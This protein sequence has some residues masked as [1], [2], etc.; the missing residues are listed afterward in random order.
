MTQ[1]IIR[2]GKIGKVGDKL[3]F[4]AKLNE[5]NVYT[6]SNRKGGLAFYYITEWTEE[7]TG[8][9]LKVIFEDYTSVG[10]A[11]KGYRPG[12]IGFL[13]ATVVEHKKREHGEEY[14]TVLNR[15]KLES[16]F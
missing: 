10:K 2:E 12:N 4:V 11:F 3:K 6:T 7:E 15:A 1:K 5:V 16:F 9:V 13:E 14:T 8:A